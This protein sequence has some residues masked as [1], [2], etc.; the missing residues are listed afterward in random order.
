[1]STTMEETRTF[2]DHEQIMKNFIE[3]E[4]PVGMAANDMF[5]VVKETLS[6]IGLKSRR[7]D[8]PVLHQ[9]CH[10]LN[11]R[12]RFFIVHF[13][14]LFALDGKRSTM[15]ESDVMRRNTIAKMIESFNL[16]Q[17]KNPEVIDD[18]YVEPSKAISKGFVHLIRY[19]DKDNWNLVPKYNIGKY[20]K[21]EEP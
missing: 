12:G 20:K 3:I 13:K 7:D 6:R 16:A 19:R 11:K 18:N 4:E 9:S 5:L 1:M 17:I 14:E 15:D 10:I 2:E 21:R 8:E